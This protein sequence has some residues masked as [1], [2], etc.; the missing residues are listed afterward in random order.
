M[1]L[2]V[3][4]L[5]S[6]SNG[7][8]YYA[9]NETDAVFIDA[10]ISCT[11]TEKR[12]KLLGLKMDNIRAIFVS[13]EHADH[14][15]GL[16]TLANKYRLP[17]Y[18]TAATAASG[19]RLIRHLSKPFTANEPLLI[20]SLRVTAFSKQH[21][22][23]DPHSF[24]VEDQSATV[25]IFTDIGAACKEVIHYFQKCHAAFL[26]SNYDEDMLARGPYSA[27][28]KERI[29]G[30]YG[31]LSNSQALELFTRYRPPFMTHLFLSHLSHI[32]NSVETVQQL[33]GPHQS[34]TNIVISS[35]N[36]ATG[37][38]TIG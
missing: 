1:S 33:F 18:I 21:D 30:N 36:E 28:L 23:T 7:N 6:G 20:G 38:F 13:H 37:V 16:S 10:G 31:H 12:M 29:S 5:N 15:R 26:E 35:R 8:C 19:P 17:V 14:I 22:A 25:G 32:N 2:F 9:G 24:I 11:E 34:G 4:S 3:A 27:L